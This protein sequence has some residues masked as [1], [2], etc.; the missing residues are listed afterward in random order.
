[1]VQTRT[2]LPSNKALKESESKS[3]VY[4]LTRMVVVV[5]NVAAKNE[6]GNDEVIFKLKAVKLRLEW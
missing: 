4:H 5:D 2:Y 3:W 6:E 1:M